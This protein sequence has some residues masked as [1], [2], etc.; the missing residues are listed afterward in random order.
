MKISKATW[1]YI[2]AALITLYGIITRSFILI[3]LAFPMGLF[4][5]NATDNNKNE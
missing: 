2:I 1:F 4:G 3:L 5:L